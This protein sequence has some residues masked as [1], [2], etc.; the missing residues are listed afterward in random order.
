MPR[1]LDPEIAVSFMIEHGLEPLEQ[2]PGAGNQ[3]RCRCLTCGDEVT[4]RYAN[5]K[6]GWGACPRCRRLAQSRTRRGPEA[7]AI[8]DFQA[9]GLEPL[10]PYLSVMTPWRSQCRNC[11]RVVSPTLNNVRRGQGPCGW[12]SG[13][14]VDSED[15]VALMRAASLEPLD[16]YPGRHAPWPC[17]CLRCG[18]VV[19]PTY[20]AV[21]SGGGCR[22]CNDPAIRP[23]AAEAE[24]RSAQLQPLEPYPGS[25][26]KW[27]CRCL[28]CNMIV[29]P[30]Y[31]T[32]QRG[33]GGCRWCRNSG[34][35]AANDA[36]VYLITHTDLHAAK[37]GITD[38]SGS[39]LKKHRTRGWQVLCTITVSGERAMLI[40]DEILGW[41]RGELALPAYLGPQDMKQ[42][43][44]T[45]TVSAEEVDL[46]ATIR[47]IQRLAEGQAEKP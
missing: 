43:G 2:Y 11:G 24:M 18:Q 3:W 35:K 15:A 30:C 26:A 7:K 46:A 8:A 25:V 12:C 31:S 32:I 44:W 22:Y 14:R 28:K 20:G 17:R 34:F 1:R 45:E 27:R 19:S 4:P 6:Q 41:W 42:G 39:R 47:H 29:T 23:E 38:S 5:I 13:K 40:E 9:V 16:A 21:K 10:Q 33:S 37:I 36:M